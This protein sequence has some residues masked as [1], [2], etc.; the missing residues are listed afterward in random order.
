[1]IA[2][3]DLKKIYSGA[4]VVNVSQLEIRKG[5]SVG[6]VGN[7]GAGK[8]TLFRLML[9]LIRADSGEVLSNGE[10]CGGH[11]NWK[12]PPP[13]QCLDEAQVDRLF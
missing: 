6:L 12:N 5:E 1:M 11:E 8:T 10:K 9:D 4:T 7:N 3:K 13:P 2:I